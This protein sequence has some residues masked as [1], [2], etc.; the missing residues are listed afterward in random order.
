MKRIF[1]ILASILITFNFP[2]IKP[3][4]EVFVLKGSYAYTTIDQSF[5]DSE[6]AFKGRT[7]ETVLRNFDNFKVVCGECDLVLYRTFVKNP[8]KFWLWGEYILYEKYRLPYMNLPG[9]YKYGTIQYRCQ[10][11]SRNI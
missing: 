1:I 10:N 8:W 11:P 9:G 2:P 3:F 6:M 4:I 5:Y 7:Y